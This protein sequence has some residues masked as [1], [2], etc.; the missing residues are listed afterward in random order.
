MTLRQRRGRIRTLAVSG[1]SSDLMGFPGTFERVIFSGYVG[2]AKANDMKMV[3]TTKSASGD[4]MMWL[5]M[6]DR[7]VNDNLERGICTRPAAICKL[8][9]SVAE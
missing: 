1:P 7:N 2:S 3:I 4:L 9:Q 6:R 8:Q 5:K